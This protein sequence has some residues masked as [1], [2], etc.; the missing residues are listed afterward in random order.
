MGFV[1][2]L[3]LSYL[4]IVARALLRWLVSGRCL[5][6]I[7][8]ISPLVTFTS[9]NSS[10]APKFM[11]ACPGFLGGVQYWEYFVLNVGNTRKPRNAT[12]SGCF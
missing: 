10:G 6:H 9:S 2:L 4:L 3:L 5:T 1:Y 12:I 11:R 7:R 8:N